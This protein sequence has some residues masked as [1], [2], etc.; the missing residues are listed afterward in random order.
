MSSTVSAV[1]PS[2]ATSAEL[3]RRLGDVLPPARVVVQPNVLDGYSHDS[4]PVAVVLEKLGRHDYRPDV[5]VRARDQDDVAATL[6]VASLLGVPV[7]ARGLGSSVTGQALPTRG[8]VVLD[9]SGLDGEPQLDDTD[10]TVTAAAG[11]RGSDLEEW[12][13]Q[14]G[15]T[16]NFFPQSL[17]RSSIGGWLATRATGQLSSKYGGIED[18][19]VRYT[20]VLAD[21]SAVEVGQRPRASIGPDLR[22]LFLGS[23]GMFGVVTRVT[24][25]VYRVAETTSAAWSLPDV[26]TGV[27]AMREICQAGIRPSLMRFYD[28][29]ETRHAVPGYARGDCALFLSFDGPG[30]V[31]AAE[32]DEATRILARHGASPLG[33]EPVTSWYARRFDFSTVEGLLARDGGYA[34]TIEVA[35]LW[36]GIENLYGSLVA[37]LAPMADEVLGHFSHVY[38][39]GVSLYVILL[40]VAPDNA[41]AARR[42]ESI[43]RIAMETTLA[44]GGEISH[45]HGAG[46]ARQQFVARALGSQHDLLRRLKAALD[47]AGLLNPGHLGL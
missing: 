7:T 28:Q 43:W 21:G 23:E 22:Q 44:A 2:E 18:A 6:R 12:L 27:R 32:D 40:G 38:R 9:L 5:V 20:V 30:R 16:M 25:K 37:A 3:V 35:H 4:W 10:L 31:A 36:S 1:G 46:L 24:L 19:V 17:D 42:L 33:A 45:H 47:P 13:A 11:I 15:Y 41:E 39:Q 14:R 34:E 29:A 26:A 8:G